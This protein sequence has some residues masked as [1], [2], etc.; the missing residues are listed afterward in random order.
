MSK[1]ES[2]TKAFFATLGRLSPEAEAKTAEKLAGEALSVSAF[3]LALSKASDPASQLLKQLSPEARHQF[4]DGIQKTAGRVLS[5]FKPAKTPVLSNAELR[6]AVEGGKLFHIGELPQGP[7]HNL[8]QR[9]VE[10]GK[11]PMGSQIQRAG[12]KTELAILATRNGE[13]IPVLEKTMLPARALREVKAASVGEMM[14]FTSATPST[15]LHRPGVVIQQYHGPTLEKFAG[16]LDDQMFARTRDKWDY[17][18]VPR[19][20][21][22]LFQGTPRLTGQLEQAQAQRIILGDFNSTPANFVIGMQG[23]RQTIGNIQMHQ[24]FE[25]VARP[26]SPNM[27]FIRGMRL[28]DETL[29]RIGDFAGYAKS[30]AG[31][32]AMKRAGVSTDEALFMQK[33]MDWLQNHKHF[34][35]YR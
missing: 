16:Q 25:S 24:A 22:I 5:E 7:L 17:D 19:F 6:E 29:S 12:D 35:P 32:E 8:A 14:P 18:S 13:A 23:S 9:I 31:S 2:A 4:L 1:V 10:S 34:G 21:N 3:D 20:T 30:K 15:I 27:N 26:S 28:S 11:P 33:R